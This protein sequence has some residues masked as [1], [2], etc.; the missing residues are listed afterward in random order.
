MKK[1]LAAVSAVSL[2]L[3]S[4]AASAQSLSGS[5]VATG[6]LN[7]RQTLGSPL[8]CPLNNIPISTSGGNGNSTTGA[9]P[10]N[11]QILCSFGPGVNVTMTSDWEL[12]PISYDEI[13]IRNVTANAL[14]GTCGPATLTAEVVDPGADLI[15]YIPFQV[16]SGSPVG[17]EVEGYVTISGVALL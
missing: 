10:T 4:G 14:A 12:V 5:G 11:P 7:L 8:A 15:L 3:V 13:E 17:C 2:I 16:I 6:D 1:V 9:S